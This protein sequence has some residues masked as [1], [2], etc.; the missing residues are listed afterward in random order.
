MCAELTF[1]S[2]FA[3]DAQ[4][5]DQPA[6]YPGGTWGTFWAHLAAGTA[7]HTTYKPAQDEHKHWQLVQGGPPA[8]ASGPDR[9]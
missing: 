4:I 5:D 1:M 9:Q 6:G 7:W 3:G 2:R 8:S